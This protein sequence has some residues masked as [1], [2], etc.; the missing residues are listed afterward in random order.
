MFILQVFSEKERD[1]LTFCLISHDRKKYYLLNEIK[2]N[3]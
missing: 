2:K 3:L 1:N